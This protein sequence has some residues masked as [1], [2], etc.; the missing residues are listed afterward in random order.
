[1]ANRSGGRAST[2][3][4]FASWPARFTLV[5]RKIPDEGTS[6]TTLTY[7]DTTV[8]PKANLIIDKPDDGGDVLYDLSP[9][10]SKVKPD[11]A[12]GSKF[13]TLDPPVQ[14]SFHPTSMLM[15]PIHVEPIG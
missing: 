6:G 11:P 14:S 7:Y 3:V 13:L 10:G 8:E 2:T 12:G 9:R 1:M 15:S 4:A 5:Q